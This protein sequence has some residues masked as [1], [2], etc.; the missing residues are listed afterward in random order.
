MFSRVVCCTGVR[1]RQ[2]ASE[3]VYIWERVNFRST[4]TFF[5]H[6]QHEC[7]WGKTD[8]RHLKLVKTVIV[9][10]SYPG[11]KLLTLS[12]LQ[13]LS[14]AYAADVFEN[15]ELKEAFKNISNMENK[16]HVQ[17]IQYLVEQ[18][19][20]TKH[21]FEQYLHFLL[22]VWKVICFNESVNSKEWERSIDH[23]LL[24]KVMNTA[25]KHPSVNTADKHQS[26]KTAVE[27]RSL[28]TAD[29][30]SQWSLQI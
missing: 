23:T 12:Q 5:Q 10:S 24:P 7:F 20:G 30:T 8:R 1:K 21:R 19:V 13:T 14:D 26:V 28:R 29:K 6:P 27:Y 25:E 16:T 4:F 22:S 18:I 3:S 2:K 9:L 11:V 15:I 17:C